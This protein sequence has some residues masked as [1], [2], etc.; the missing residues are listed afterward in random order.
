MSGLREDG[1][2][3]EGR[4][5]PPSVTLTRLARGPRLAKPDREH[6]PGHLAKSLLRSRH[7]SPRPTQALPCTCSVGRICSLCPWVVWKVLSH[8]S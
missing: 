7:H 2:R 5:S 6:G 1:L 4:R 3:L 8:L